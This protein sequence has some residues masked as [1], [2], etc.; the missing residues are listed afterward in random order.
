MSESESPFPCRLFP[1]AFTGTAPGSPPLGS[2]R[3]PEP[4]EVVYSVGLTL[5]RDGARLSGKPPN[6]NSKI[7]PKS[8]SEQC[9]VPGYQSQTPK[10]C[11]SGKLV[12]RYFS[13]YPQGGK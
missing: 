3:D 10:V 5:G 12:N 1:R 4:Q 11:D 7:G 13:I 8:L 9:T 2:P 6:S